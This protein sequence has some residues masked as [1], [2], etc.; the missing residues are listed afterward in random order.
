MV[1]YLPDLL[2]ADRDGTH[3]IRLGVETQHGRGRV[4]AI[5]SVPE[6]TDDPDRPAHQRRGVEVGRRE[7]LAGVRVDL[8][9]VGVAHDDVVVD[10]EL[11]VVVVLVLAGDRDASPVGHGDDG[12]AEPPVRPPGLLGVEAIDAVRLAR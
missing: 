4:H 7:D 8:D 5:F 10:A 2:T 3:R 11:G 9:V 12:H 6:R 1:V